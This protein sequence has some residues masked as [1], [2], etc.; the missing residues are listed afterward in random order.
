MTELAYAIDFG[1]SNTLVAAASAEEVFAPAELDP[2]AEDSTVLRSILYF[3]NMDQVYF[4]KEAITEFVANDME[5][6]LLRSFKRFLPNRSFIGTF[7]G[8]RPV[9]LEDAISIFLRQVRLRA[10]KHY[11]AEV[12]KVVLGR[13]A[14]F[15]ETE[16][17]D[18]FAEQRLRMAAEKAGFTDVEFYPEPLAAARSFVGEEDKATTVLISDLGGGTSDFSIVRLDPSDPDAMEV[19]GIGGLSVAGDAMDSQL[20]R[21]R[22]SKFFGADVRYK[23]PMGSNEMR[24]PKALLEHICSPAEIQILRERDTAAF[25]RQ[26]RDWAL[27]EDDRKTMDRLFTLIEDQLGFHVFELIEKAKREL[28]QSESTLFQFEYPG[29]SFACSI[30]KEE[31]EDYTGRKCEQILTTMR[32]TLERAGLE[33]EDIDLVLCTGG[34]S[35]IPAIREGL[36]ADFTEEK[37]RNYDNFHSVIRGLAR[38]AQNVY[39]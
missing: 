7:I 17:D 19:L 32:H 21:R 35:K 6:R 39:F 20:M 23:V 38:H 31:F 1:T 24:M 13:P 11:G 15:A 33:K 2:N 9:H 5:G 30:K 28:S 22:V 27:S 26:V 8:N 12:T 16:A 10:D 25:L 29:A 34:T 36:V 37:V 14:L 3:P 4:G 18:F